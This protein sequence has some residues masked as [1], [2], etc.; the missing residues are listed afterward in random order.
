MRV[1]KGGS[2]MDGR[3]ENGEGKGKV[4]PL[5]DKNDTSGPPPG[6]FLTLHGIVRYDAV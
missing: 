3:V 6:T 2:G 4:K 1:E 5:S